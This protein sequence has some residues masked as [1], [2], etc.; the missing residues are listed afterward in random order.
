MRYTQVRLALAAWQ[1]DNQKYPEKLQELSPDYF[2][3]TVATDYLRDTFG[4]YPDGLDLPVVLSTDQYTQH[5]FGKAH[6]V[7]SVIPAKTPFL[8]PWTAF[9]TQQSY[10]QIWIPD[11][12]DEKQFSKTDPAVG[13]LMGMYS[14]SYSGWYPNNEYPELYVFGP[15]QPAAHD[16]DE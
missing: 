13:Y 15:E 9:P 12:Q 6:L 11:E 8:L 5:A 10:F 7:D 4:Y 16:S 14:T 2:T 1:C 3:P